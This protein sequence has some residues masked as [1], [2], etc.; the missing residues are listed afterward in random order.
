MWPTVEKWLF[1]PFAHPH[2]LPHGIFSFFSDRVCWVAYSFTHFKREI[3]NFFIFFHFFFI[4]FA[5]FQKNHFLA[6]LP[7]FNAPPWTTSHRLWPSFVPPLPLSPTNL[8]MTFYSLKFD[9]KPR[10]CGIKREKKNI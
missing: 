5:H 10:S 3:G 8:S 2:G 1:P 9:E 6:H 4:I 7:P